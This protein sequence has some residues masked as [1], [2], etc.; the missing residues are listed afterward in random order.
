MGPSS[1]AYNDLSDAIIGTV[2]FLEENSKKPTTSNCPCFTTQYFE[3]DP[4][5]EEEEESR[6]NDPPGTNSSDLSLS[7]TRPPY[8]TSYSDTT[9][10]CQCPPG[11]KVNIQVI[12]DLEF[13]ED[14][15]QIE[16]N[17]GNSLFRPKNSKQINIAKRTFFCRT[18][19]FDTSY[20][21]PATIYVKEG[22]KTF[23]KRCVIKD[24]KIL[25]L[26]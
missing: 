3:P 2:E 14:A 15:I 21:G 19:K 7:F 10:S 13:P 4:E 9:S 5:E 17:R 22:S 8:I 12:E 26:P 1:N 24:G 23:K 6:E 18:Y 16:D 20:E 25:A 11:A